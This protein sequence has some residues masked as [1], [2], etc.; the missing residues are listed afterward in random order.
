MKRVG[1]KLQGTVRSG[2]LLRPMSN[3]TPIF[4]ALAL[5]LSILFASGSARAEVSD[6]RYLT[7]ESPESAAER[8]GREVGWFPAG[9]IFR[10]LLADLRQPRFYA[11]LRSADFPPPSLPSS[12]ESSTT[13]GVVGFGTEFGVLR[14]AYEARCE[15]WQIDFW[16][17]ALAQFDMDAPSQA[18]INTDFLVGISAT[19]RSGNWSTRLRL[20][21]QSSHL[22]D[23]FL[24]ANPGVPRID[25]SMEIVDA[26]ASYESSWWRVY[27]GGGVIV[28]DNPELDPGILQAGFE[29]RS[30]KRRGKIGWSPVGGIDVQ[31]W[32]A[33][34]WGTTTSVTGGIEMS[35][36]SG[37]RRFRILAAYLRG[38]T[39]FGQFFTVQKTT[40]YGINLHFDL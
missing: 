17:A 25:L 31:A 39:P 6:C 34:D 18:H 1:G 22:G 12:G 3:R 35:N 37:T 29:A 27:G 23:E 13:T 5:A 4:T 2:M 33:R 7:T 26:L 28:R 30:P 40:D 21:H 9:G 38:Y 19:L 10:P 16:G 8:S 32:Q 11:G 20:Y 14:R 36:P 15:G 24:L